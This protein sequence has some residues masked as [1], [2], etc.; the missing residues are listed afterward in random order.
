MERANVIS[1]I[2]RD[3]AQVFFASVLIDPIIRFE[4]KPFVIV[5]GVLLSLAAW[6]VSLIVIKNK[7]D[8][9]NA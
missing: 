8:G 2:C 7:K 5:V 3:I 6:Y 1:E 4:F 9:S